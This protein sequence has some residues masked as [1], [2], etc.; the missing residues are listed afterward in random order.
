M[1]WLNQLPQTVLSLLHNIVNDID[2]KNAFRGVF[3]FFSKGFTWMPITFVIRNF[4]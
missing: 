1:L 3:L 4:N 2:F